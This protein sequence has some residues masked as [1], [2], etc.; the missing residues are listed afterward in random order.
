MARPL[1][2]EIENGIYHVTSRGWEKR[3]IV[4][5]DRDRTDWLRMLGD[6]AVRYGWRVFSWMLM[7]NHFHLFLRT[8]DPNLSA[9]MHDLNSGYASLFNRRHR[10]VGALFRGRFKGILVEDE[11]HAWELSRY[12]HLNPVR[13]KMAAHPRDYAWGSYRDYCDVRKAPEWLDWQ[14]VISEYGRSL[15]TARRAYRRFVE[16]GVEQEPDSPLAAAVAGTFLGSPDWILKI[17]QE[18]AD[19]P[20]DANVPLLRELS[21]RPSADEVIEAVAR[22][23]RVETTEMTP[24]RR[25]GNHTRQMAIYLIRQ[26]TTDSL[27][28]VASRFGGV[29]AAAICKTA[30]RVNQRYDEE[31]RFQREANKIRKQ[32]TTKS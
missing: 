26:L 12:V 8:P 10:R 20:P 7:S 9:G 29:S 25:H 23:Y 32:L 24:A 6:V 4:H 22:H 27:G 14:T 1:R 11:S 16:A 28:A 3:V 31:P 15:V 19:K 5:G 21:W 13:A 30:K 17:R 18:L 2:I